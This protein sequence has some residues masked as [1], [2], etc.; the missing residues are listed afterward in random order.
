VA[1]VAVDGL[2]FPEHRERYLD[3]AR[4]VARVGGLAILDA[5]LKSRRGQPVG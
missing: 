5:R 3:L 1:V 4:S 2:A